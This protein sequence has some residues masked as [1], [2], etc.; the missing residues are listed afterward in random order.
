M[1]FK[2]GD[3]VVLC[4]LKKGQFAIFENGHEGKIIDISEIQILVQFENG[5]YWWFDKSN[6]K[7]NIR[8]IRDRKLK[9]LGI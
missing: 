7:L 3:E 5:D 6:L 2:E 1:E 9:E 4:G 8:S